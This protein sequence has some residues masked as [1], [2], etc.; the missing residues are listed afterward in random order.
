MGLVELVVSLI[1]VGV[2]L[3][4]VNNF[5]PMDEKIKQILNVV[6]VIAVV[7]WL[8]QVSGLLSHVGNIRFGK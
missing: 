2:I 1:V 8:L 4:C 7:F 5:I 3:Y 6:V